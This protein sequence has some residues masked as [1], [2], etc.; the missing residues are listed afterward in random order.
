MEEQ[1]YGSPVLVGGAAV[2]I[3]SNSA[4]ATGDFDIVTAW[5]AEFETN[6]RALGFTRPTGAGVATRGWVHPELAL[7]FEVVS[8]T[9]FSGL[10]DR[11]RVRLLDLGEDGVAAIVSVED[12]IADRVGQYA[13][14]TASDMLDQARALLRLHP[15]VDFGYLDERI[16]YESAGDFGAADLA[17]TDTAS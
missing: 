17:D 3:Y 7:G 14:G 1:G 8:S 13:S 9:L 6:L 12:V 2:E 15:E 16:R 10:A 11:N 5:Q 4:V